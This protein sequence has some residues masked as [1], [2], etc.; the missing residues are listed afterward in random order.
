MT[1]Q[2]LIKILRRAGVQ[3][4]QIADVITAFNA[5]EAAGVTQDDVDD[6]VAEKAEIL[7]AAAIIDALPTENVASPGIWSDEG[8]LKVGTA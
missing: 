5:A 4:T 7:A 8:V 6:I 1:N 3:E 2:F